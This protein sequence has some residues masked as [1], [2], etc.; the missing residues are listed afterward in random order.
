[1]IFPIFLNVI[2]GMICPFKQRTII[3][4]VF[5]CHSH[6]DTQCH[7][8]DCSIPGKRF[9]HVCTQLFR[10]RLRLLQRSVLHKDHK[11]IPTDTSDNRFIR[12]L[13]A[14]QCCNIRYHHVS[15]RMSECVIDLLKVVNINDVEYMRS[16]C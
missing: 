15:N 2:H 5:S 3:I 13:F 10:F 8:N 1:M 6:T 4:P 12:K 9:L 14:Y 7:N 11:F 16:L